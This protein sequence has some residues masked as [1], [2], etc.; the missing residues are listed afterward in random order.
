MTATATDALA[1]FVATTRLADIPAD[2]VARGRLIIA[3][4]VGCM[5]AGAVVPEVRRLA[6]LQSNRGAPAA[7]VLGTG[8]R[9]AADAAGF[10]NGTAGTWHDLD[11]G[12]LSTRTH[13]AIQIVPA[14]LA[15]AEARAF[16]GQEFLT[17][18]ILA[19]EA[20]ARL[21]RA[22]TARHAV[23]PHG[24]YGPLAAAFA[25]AKLRGDD[26]AATARAA[27]TAATL[28]IAASR[29]SLDD[30]ATVRNIYS[31]HSARAGFEALA[32][33]DAG[34]T[35]EADAVTSI[36]GNI[37]G[38]AFDAASAT[39]ALGETW[40]IRRNYF[41]RFASGRYA[42]GALDLVEDLADRMGPRLSASDIELIDVETFFWAATLAAQTVR[43]PF[44]LRFSLPMA[45]AQRIVL[46]P[47]RLTDDG[48]RAFG[49]L[50][51][52]DLARRIFVVE[53]KAATAAYPER[54]P[55]RM[56]VTFRDGTCRT[57]SAER[58]LGESDHPLPDGALEAKFVA[59]VDEAWGGGAA[60]AWRNLAR[61][62]VIADIRQLID[63]WRGTITSRR[64]GEK[65][66]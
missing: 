46:G 27:N 58:I 63:R 3:D 40:W 37:Y 48:A 29:K 59:L 44:G 51:V 24:T 65:I 61:I 4:C 14:A 26:A 13:A 38:S 57:L 12:N 56:T 42:H 47:L 39:A 49:N 7:T 54:Q 20:G 62:D 35:G 66:K 60:A 2:V 1:D 5:I 23:H 19:Y 45:I 21:W 17:A 33:R 53:D 18:V 28:G 32:L 50:Q 55:T 31:G 9:L 34:F 15:E 41:K 22:T 30:G 8:Q 25:L 10:I 16:S 11:E 64:A 6:A 52:E 43:T 36:M